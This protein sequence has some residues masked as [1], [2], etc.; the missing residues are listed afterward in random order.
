MSFIP[1]TRDDILNYT[2]SMSLDLT[3]PLTPH[4]IVVKYL[5]DSNQEYRVSS[6]EVEDLIDSIEY[7]VALILS[8]PSL[9][10]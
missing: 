4:A 1:P 2:K 9:M 3:S 7:D 6:D 10:L 8:D 5:K